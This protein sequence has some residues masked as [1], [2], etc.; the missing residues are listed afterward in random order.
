MQFPG[1]A[2]VNLFATGSL[3]NGSG[4]FPSGVLFE[5]LVI[6][7]GGVP[8]HQLSKWNSEREC[9]STGGRRLSCSKPIDLL[10]F[11]FSHFGPYFVLA[12]K[13]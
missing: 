13:G 10:T 3:R 7:F 2:A 1:R 11:W 5:Q 12:T 6:A 8:L 9:P 4:H